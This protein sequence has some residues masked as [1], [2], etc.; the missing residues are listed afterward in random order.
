MRVLVLRMTPMSPPIASWWA[1]GDVLVE[2]AAQPDEPALD[3]ARE[4]LSSKGPEATWEEMMDTVARMSPRSY[5][6]WELHETRDPQA[7]Q[8]RLQG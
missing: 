3:V 7:L 1:Q 6:V 5:G 4:L 8:R 2:K